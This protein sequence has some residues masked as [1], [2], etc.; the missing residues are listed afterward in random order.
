[1]GEI[2]WDGVSDSTIRILGLTGSLRVGS[3][4]MGL[5]CAAQELA[6][7]GVEIEIADIRGVPLY[8]EDLNHDGGPEAVRNLKAQ[9]H[10]ADALLFAVP[11]YNYSMT[12]VQKN[13]IDW[14]SRP[15]ESSPLRH[16]PVALMGAGARFGT[17]RA[18]LA[19]R[20]VFLFTESYAM[21][22]PELMIPNAPEHFDSAGQ[23]I[24]E[25]LR[26]RVR[27]IVEAL[28]LW[29]RQVSLR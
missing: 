28:A 6:P 14:L 9:T 19:L 24:D 1:M 18:Q 20:Q 5:L 17:V 2:G 7:A 25:A 26:Q 29:T 11:E 23:L 22:K 4:N 13:V 27:V 10:A 8:N 12:G 16:K 3:Y 21:I 15:V